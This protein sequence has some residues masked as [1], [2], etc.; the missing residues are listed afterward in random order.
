MRGFLIIKTNKRIVNVRLYFVMATVPYLLYILTRLYLNTIYT[1][2]STKNGIINR[3][4]QTMIIDALILPSSLSFSTSTQQT[5]ISGSFTPAQLC[6]ILHLLSQKPFSANVTLIKSCHTIINL[7]TTINSHQL[8]TS[9]F[10]NSP[11]HNPIVTLPTPLT[12][13]RKASQ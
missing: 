10:F 3:L 6:T 11:V 4:I 5:A 13:S 2:S 8:S 7:L 12:H 9:N 1:V